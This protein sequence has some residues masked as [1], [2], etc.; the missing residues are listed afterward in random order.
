M[1]F[2]AY[3]GLDP[4]RHVD[5]ERLAPRVLRD[6]EESLVERER[7]DERGDLAKDREDL[8]R[9]L[10]VLAEV[11]THDDEL[12]TQ[13]H[14]PRHRQRRPHPESSRFVARRRDDAAA[15]RAPADGNRPSAQRRV[16]PLLDR[17]VERVHVHVKDLAERGHCGSEARI[18]CT[19]F[20]T[21]AS[22]Y[23]GLGTGT[24]CVT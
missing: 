8:A 14:G 10:T 6:V 4:A 13:P 19:Q 5:G 22:S 12:R 18:D 20:V 9:G 15:F 16:V 3:P 24:A 17:R 7:L 23:S 2:F 1:G 21:I 11:G